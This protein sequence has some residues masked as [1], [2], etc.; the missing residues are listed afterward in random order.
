VILQQNGQWAEQAKKAIHSATGCSAL[1]CSLA[2]NGHGPSPLAL[3]RLVNALLIPSFSYGWPVWKPSESQFNTLDSLMV[4]VLRCALTAP[5][6]SPSRQLLLEAGLPDTHSLFTSSA[7]LFARTCRKQY[8]GVRRDSVYSWI[9]AESREEMLGD[10]GRLASAYERSISTFIQQAVSDIGPGAKVRC[11]S[12]QFSRLA[13]R[14]RLERQMIQAFDLKHKHTANHSFF[15]QTIKQRT[16]KKKQPFYIRFD[17]KTACRYRFL[18]RSHWNQLKASMFDHHLPD[19][20]AP[21]CSICLASRQ[22]ENHIILDC[23]ELE[24]DRAI[25]KTA[26]L[27]VCSERTVKND[28]YR[29]V[30]AD[31]D[32]AAIIPPLLDKMKLA[33]ERLSETD[34]LKWILKK[35]GH[36]LIAAHAK[37]HF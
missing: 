34:A 8:D 1:L 15:G 3:I 33:K 20:P 31:F 28:L 12:E 6:K 17:A 18:L 16:M 14:H 25:L 21:S 2:R 27:R 7:L 19:T 24:A 11:D 10:Q 35:T 32:R 26:L 4:K 23:R 13:L 37:I 30:M 5:A 22:D 29:L 36:F 9:D